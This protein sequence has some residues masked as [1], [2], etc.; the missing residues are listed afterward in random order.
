MALL[1]DVG[2]PSRMT[3][4]SV[5]DALAPLLPGVTVHCGGLL[6]HEV[7]RAAGY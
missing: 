6:L 3:D 7:D 4:E 2:L 5:R 1:I